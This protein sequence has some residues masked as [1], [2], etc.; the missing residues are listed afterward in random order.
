MD[1]FKISENIREIIRDID[2]RKFNEVLIKI[3]LLLKNYPNLNILDWENEI[4]TYEKSLDKKLEKFKIYIN[5]GVILFKLGKITESITA[6]EKSIKS[7]PNF[8]LAYNNLAVSFLEL[9][10]FQEASKYFALALKFNKDD[11]SAQKHLINIFNLVSPKNHEENN[12]INLNFKI[13]NIVNDLNISNY[14]LTKNIKKI[15]GECKNLIANSKENIIFNETQIFRKNSENLNC[16][17]HFKVFNEFNII[18]KYCFECYKIQINLFTIIDL[19]KLYFIFDLMYLKNN[20]LRKCMVETRNQISG[21][22]KG[23]IYCT[24]LDE[25]NKLSKIINEEM[26]KNNLNDFKISLKHGC[27]EFYESYPEFKNIDNKMNYKEEWLV[28]EKLIDERTPIRMEKDK[29]IWGNYVKGLNL[30]DILIIFN[31]INYAQLIGDLSY[32]KIFEKEIKPNFLNKIL[33]NQLEF[34]KNIFNNKLY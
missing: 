8:S 18:P 9:G 17:R 22:Y 4:N 5:V 32:K 25:A 34:R 31:W 11:L 13:K 19:I 26:N 2:N 21:N 20:N 33:E 10:M 27:S 7:N 24:G 12:L 15:L 6:F 3:E 1:N 14:F 29:K 23:Y 16:F 30:S 28:K